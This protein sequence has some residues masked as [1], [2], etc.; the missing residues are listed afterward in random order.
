[1]AAD[2][3]FEMV[4]GEEPERS[5][6]RGRT[7][8]TA[9]RGRAAPIIR[10]MPG[11]PALEPAAADAQQT[12]LAAL[13]ARMA[14][15]DEAALGAFYDATMPRVYGLAV[16][17]C[18]N[19]AT[20]EEVAADTYHQCWTGAAR[21]DAARSKVLTWLLMICRSRAIDAVRARDPALAH[22][23]PE[24]LVADDDERPRER[25]PQDLL[26]H[27]QSGTAVHAALAKLSPVQRQMIGLAFFR[28][29]SHQEIAAHS[30]LP[31]G[32]VKAHIRRALELMRQAL[33]A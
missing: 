2:I 33:A 5:L 8:S 15:G 23:A 26:D 30:R 11:Q 25:D 1:M 20:A 13:V 7:A 4:A 10:R 19:A 12:D 17:I 24:T 21:Y 18:G 31:L 22:E 16:R 32:T 27:M 9:D 3:V 28:G 29:L 6:A 14:G